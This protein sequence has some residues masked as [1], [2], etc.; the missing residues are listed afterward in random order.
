MSNQ[1]P[2]NQFDVPIV[3]HEYGG[4]QEFN[5]PAPFW[6]QLAFYLCIAFAFGYYV[7]YELG[8][9]P[10]S[11][12]RLASE[13]AL[14]HQ[15]QNA[16]KPAGPDEKTLQ[17]MMAQADVMK[18]GKEVYAGKCA[19]CHAPDGGGLVGPN[20]TDDYWIHGKGTLTDI[21]KVV[22]DGVSDKGMPPWGP[23]LS[24]AELNAVVV[25]VKSLQGAKAAA[26][27]APQGNKI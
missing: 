18:V 16:N 1:D 13:L 6:W 15:A 17:A 14:V 9:A 2:K 7:Y 5:N 19:A 4:I 25:Y 10:S 21:H 20:L 8:T 3:D 11:D 12:S 26:P 24:E 27:K 22:H 23:V